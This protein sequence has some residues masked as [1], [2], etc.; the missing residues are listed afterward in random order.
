M[1]CLV[2]GAKCA[3]FAIQ[4]PPQQNSF[5]CPPKGSSPASETKKSRFRNQNVR[6]RNQNDSETKMT[7]SATKTEAFQNQNV[8][9][10]KQKNAIQKPKRTIQKPKC[11]IQK[12]KFSERK[13]QVFCGTE[14]GGW[15]AILAQA[16]QPPC[17]HVAFCDTF[18]WVRGQLQCIPSSPKLCGC[19]PLGLFANTTICRTTFGTRS[20]RLRGTRWTTCGF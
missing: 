19:N 6:F 11:T 16:D 7:D 1:V 15:S 8:P 13:R 3:A 5:E 18:D 9:V 2:K 17:H 14:A 12:P 4:F 10:Q 20:C